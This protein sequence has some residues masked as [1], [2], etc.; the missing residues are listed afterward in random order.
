[1]KETIIKTGTCPS[2]SGRSEL[3]YCISSDNTKTLQLTITGNSGKGLYCKEPI[4]MS[5]ILPTDDDPFSSGTYQKYFKGKSINTAGFILAILKHLG[6]IQNVQGSSRS[7]VRTKEFNLET[8]QPPSKKVK[9]S[10][11]LVLGLVVQ[12][13]YFMGM[14]E[15]LVWMLIARVTRDMIRA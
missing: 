11:A 1:M 5:Q 8:L 6:A 3:S 10:A 7:Y 13:G 9:P 15:L 2:L 14:I 4:P 12:F